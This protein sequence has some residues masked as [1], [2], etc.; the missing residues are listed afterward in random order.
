M[1]EVGKAIYGGGYLLSEDAAKARAEAEQQAIEIAAR[2]GVRTVWPISER[3]RRIAN[4]LG[5]QRARAANHAA[6]EPEIWPG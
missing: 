3:E 5:D 2:G 4:R 1:K 6:A